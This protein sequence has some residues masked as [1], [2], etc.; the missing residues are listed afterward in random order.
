[1]TDNAN[2]IV[3]EFLTFVQNKIDKLDDLTLVQICNSHFSDNEVETGKSVLFTA[4]SDGSSSTTRLVSRKG[5]DKRKKNIKDVIRMFKETEPNLHPVFVARD[6]NR[7]PPV[8]FDHIDVSCLLK[9]ITTLKT[10][11]QKLRC[12]SSSKSELHDFE[13]RVLDQLSELRTQRTHAMELPQPSGGA[14]AH[15]NTTSPATSGGD[16][17]QTGSVPQAV[18][19]RS[20]DDR[21][22]TLSQPL[23][24]S[25]PT[26][27]PQSTSNLTYRDMLFVKQQ[28][29]MTRRQSEAFNSDIRS[30]V[31]EDEF[32]L[33]THRKKRRNNNNKNTVRTQ[34]KSR[35]MSGTL[36]CSSSCIEAAES[37]GA[38]YVSRLKK[39]ITVDKIKEHIESRG[40]TCHSVELLKPSRETTFNSFKVVVPISKVEVSREQFLAYSY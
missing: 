38:I 19:E 31:D 9:D 39:H 5:E 27:S 13:N 26:S 29:P 10:E 14:R 2:I 16:A 30:I 40:E 28:P 25:K 33:V 11:I 6:L 8:T 32:T 15:S 22:M 21:T 12:D 35:N 20:A 17:R 4:I 7:L 36:E 23:T 34:T 37:Y 18:A 1:M 3:N 24:N